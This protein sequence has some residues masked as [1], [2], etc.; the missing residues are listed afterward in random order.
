M[1]R[2]TTATGSSTFLTSADDLKY[3][4]MGHPQQEVPA[5]P[6]NRKRET[7]SWREEYIMTLARGF[8]LCVL[9]MIETLFMMCFF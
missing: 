3:C 5:S 1:K 4:G 8:C 7:S 9:L 6:K 2:N